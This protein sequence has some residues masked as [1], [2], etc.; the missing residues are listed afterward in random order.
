MEQFSS[1]AFS[2]TW[3]S[4]HVSVQKSLHEYGWEL[5]GLH[6]DWGWCFDT[7][8]KI[9]SLLALGRSH[10]FNWTYGVLAY[11]F[12]FNCPYV[13]R[14]YNVLRVHWLNSLDC[15]FFIEWLCKV[16][17]AFGHPSELF[18]VVEFCLG[19]PYRS[20]LRNGA[21]CGST[22]TWPI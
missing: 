6:E 8:L 22:A 10:S 13:V 17:V 16:E 15:F 7:S 21:A 2:K 12:S 14:A 9:C 11:S 5:G 19:C 4:Y 1:I 20:E 18:M 3:K